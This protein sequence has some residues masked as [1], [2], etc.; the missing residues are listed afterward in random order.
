MSEKL[1]LKTLLGQ[2]NKIPPIWIMRQAGRYLKEYRDVRNTQDDFISFCLNSEKA[3]EVT[4]QP[5]NRFN[6]DAAIIF[7]DILLIPWALKRD[8]RFEKNIG[9][10]LNPLQP[11]D[12]I[13]EDLLYDLPQ[14]LKPVSD[15]IVLTKKN[16]PR[17]VTL[18][19]FAGAPW[20]VLTYMVEGKSSKDFVKTRKWT[21]LHHE[22]I[23]RLMEILINSTAKFLYLQASAGADV[24][25]LFDSWAGI[26]SASQRDWLIIQPTKR[27]VRMLREMGC[28]QP[29]I[30]F[31][32][33]IGEGLTSYVEETA[34]TGVGLDHC[35]DPYWVD[36][37]LPKNFPVQGNLDPLSLLSAGPEMY[38]Q[39]DNI[40][41]AFSNRPHIF[42][43]GHGIIPE[44]PIKNVNLMVNYVR[45]SHKGK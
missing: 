43:L 18:I 27:I 1:I 10:I 11:S 39:I 13:H 4:L 3:A 14:K 38:R 40:I 2:K 16:L 34:V 9:P 41:D 12:D 42:N 35:V 26:V 31:P 17:E 33:G 21:W 7:S 6:F 23:N 5:I 8:V 19:G 20:T 24:L 15:A 25:M 30:G 37:N 44:T 36:E 22:K 29:I 32:K 45:D 28:N